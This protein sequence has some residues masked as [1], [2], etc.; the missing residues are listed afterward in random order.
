MSI[1]IVGAW[2]LLIPLLLA[3]GYRACLALAFLCSRRPEPPS[4]D[5]RTRFAVVIP[6]HDEELLI[7]DVIHSLARCDYPQEKIVVHVI[8]D[9]CSDATAARARELGVEVA[10]RVD[11][12]N[13]GK[14][15]ALAWMFERMDLSACNAVVIFDADNL[16]EPDFFRVMDR[17]IQLG[18]RCLQ[19]Y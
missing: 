8:A 4:G 15:Q 19:G 9:N 18:H 7:A 12:D 5:P 17:E 10:E 6:A 16:V 1:V 13:R 2:V 14:G 11:L 3:A